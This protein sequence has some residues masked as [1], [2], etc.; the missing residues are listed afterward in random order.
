MA[1]QDSEALDILRRLAPTLQG[2]QR[3]VGEIRTDVRTL[4]ES[5]IDA[6][7]RL[8]RIEASLPHLATAA[9]VERRP[10][11]TELWTMLAVM[12]ALF[13]IVLGVLPYVWKHW[14]P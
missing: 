7:E 1:D 4:R 12:L 2:L 14:P 10:T 9:A 6:R 8:V 13:A 11:R 5:V 3:D